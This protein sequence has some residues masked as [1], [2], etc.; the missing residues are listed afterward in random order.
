MDPFEVFF[1]SLPSTDLK[2]LIDFMSQFGPV[3]AANIWTEMPTFG[4][5]PILRGVLRFWF[6]YSATAAIRD[7]S[8]QQVF[9]H[10]SPLTILRANR[11]RLGHVTWYLPPVLSEF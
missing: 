6:P 8:R 5:K 3:F 2:T 10:G 4:C 11:S 7:A 9:F 1:P